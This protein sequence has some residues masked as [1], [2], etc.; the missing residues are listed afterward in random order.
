MALYL[1]SADLNDVQQAMALGFVLGVT[2]NPTLIA[3][4]GRPGLD[5]LRDLL[6]L[7]QGPV[8]YQVTAETVEGRAAQAREA[9]SLAP[10]R[11][12]IKIPATTENIALAARLT[13]RER[14]RCAITAVSSPAQAYLAVQAGVEFAIPYVNRLTRQLGDGIAVLREVAAIVQGSCT[15]VLA[16]SLKTPDEVVAAVLA[17]AHDVTVPLGVILALGEH[18]LS[19]KAIADFAA[20]VQ[21]SA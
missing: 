10:E 15:R 5:V 16:A 17:G 18:E 1:D 7:T 3:K 11:V 6:R 2:T 21:G 13:D 12:V 4:V 14:V 8:F 19:Y 9:A 20:S